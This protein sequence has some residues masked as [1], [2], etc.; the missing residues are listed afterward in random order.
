[1]KAETER[2][3]WY[4]SWFGEE[5]LALYPDRDDLEAD[6][7]AQFVLGLLA[8]VRREGTR[9]D[10]R[11]RLRDGAARR[12]PRPRRERR[13]RA[14]TS[15]R[16]SSPGRA[17]ARPTAAPGVRARR[18]EAA[19]VRPRLVR[20][21][22]Q[23]LHVVRATSTTRRTTSGSS[24]RSRRV[25][26]P[27]GAFLSDVFNA[28]RVLATLVSREEKT[29]AGERVS[30]PAPLR[31]VDR[32]GSRRRS[33]WE[34]ARRRARSASASASTCATSWRRSTATRASACPAAFGDFDGSPFDPRRSPRLILL[35]GRGRGAVTVPL[36]GG[37]RAFRGSP[38]GHATG[39]PDVTRFLGERA[40]RAR[41]RRARRARS[42]PRSG[43]AT[44]PTRPSPPLAAGAAGRRP[45]GAAGRPPDGAAP[46]GGEGARGRRGSPGALGGG[47]GPRAASSGAP[48]RTTT[49][50]R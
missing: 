8:P 6:R 47:D 1:M 32:G 46:D 50:S 10:P 36:D 15:R 37:P 35:A 18:H 40:S 28:S 19:P 41:D 13:S 38:S 34:P 26:A 23:L 12:R 22:R 39:E 9:R 42:S 16:R 4:A 30:H 48:P 7:Q 49:S 33:R 5:Y 31:R 14:S 29:V 43:R 20:R 2:D 3:P 27:G 21:G 45:H 11:P 44:G 17:P 25:L 24:A